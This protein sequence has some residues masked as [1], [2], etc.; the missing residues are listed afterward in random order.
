MAVKSILTKQEDF[1]GEFPANLSA[2]GLWRFNEAA[3]DSNNRLADSSGRGRDFTIINWSGTSAS[4]RQGQKG[5]YFRLNITNPTSE[6]TYLQAVNDGSIFANLGACIA[7]GGWMNP[8]TYSVGNTYCPIFNTRQGPG[9]PILYLSLIRGKPR[10]M[11]YNASGSL[12]L[13]ESVT[14]PFSLAKNCHKSVLW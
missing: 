12:I 9:Q 10:L 6:K 5:R 11:L 7:V 2:S 13:D 1:T 14:P 3:P 8:T 4:M